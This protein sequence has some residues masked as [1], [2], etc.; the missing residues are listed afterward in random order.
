MQQLTI[1]AANHS[2]RR[3]STAPYRRS[4]PELVTDEGGG[5][6]V[7]VELGSERHTVEVLATLQEFMDSRAAGAVENSVVFSLDDREYTIRPEGQPRQSDR[8]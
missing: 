4:I 1:K 5:C 7:S 6:F 8:V 3:I 2:R